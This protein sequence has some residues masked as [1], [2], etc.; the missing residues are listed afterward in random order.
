MRTII[1]LPEDQIEAL[2]EWCRRKKISR[3]EAIRQAVAQLLPRHK[4]SW[5]NHPAVGLWKGQKRRADSVEY[6]RRVR[7]EWQR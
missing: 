5:R 3:A 7:K 1:D 6:V 4:S 2:D